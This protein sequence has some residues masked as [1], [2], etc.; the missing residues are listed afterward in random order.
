MENLYEKWETLSPVEKFQYAEEYWDAVESPNK[1]Y[2]MSEFDNEFEDYPPFEVARKLAMGKFNP[3][4]G[5]FKYD[6]NGNVVSGT[7][8]D[9]MLTINDNIDEIIDYFEEKEY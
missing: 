4:D 6:H 3:Y 2:K 9:V 1:W 7:S 5:F 8:S